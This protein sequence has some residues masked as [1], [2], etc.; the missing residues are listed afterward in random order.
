VD[1]EVVVWL[2]SQHFQGS[3]RISS[4]SFKSMNA[5]NCKL[6]WTSMHII[7][8]FFEEQCIK[9]FYSSYTLQKLW[10]K[11]GNGLHLHFNAR[12]CQWYKWNKPSR[13]VGKCFVGLKSVSMLMRNCRHLYCL[14][15]LLSASS[16]CRLSEKFCRN[17]MESLLEWHFAYQHQMSL[18]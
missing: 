7:L 15:C 4:I 18:L 12:S 8:T 16:A 13:E 14:S 3:A 6:K 1:L 17:S 9:Y 2:A 10:K 5:R 11:C